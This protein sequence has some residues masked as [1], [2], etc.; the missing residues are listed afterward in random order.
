[1]LYNIFPLDKAELLIP[2]NKHIDLGLTGLELLFNTTYLD[3]IQQWVEVSFQNRDFRVY[4]GLVEVGLGQGQRAGVH[5]TYPGT[6]DCL[7]TMYKEERRA[8][9]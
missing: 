8:L 7:W 4:R 9:T 1:M 3:L 6:I 2:P 5:L